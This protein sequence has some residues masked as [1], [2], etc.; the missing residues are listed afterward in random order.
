[1]TTLPSRFWEK[2]IRT[3]TCWN[4]R[5]GKGRGYGM[6]W[7]RGRAVVAHRL[8][9]EALVGPIPDGRELD[10]LCRNRGCVNPEHLRVVDHR[11]NVLAGTAKSAINAAKACCPKGHPFVIEG[12]QRRCKVCKGARERAE[13]RARRMAKWERI[14]AEAGV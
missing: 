8:S 4:W 12:K 9:Y 13:A 6:F 2:V 10:H 5:G 14:W 3:P 1:M 11:T 7:W